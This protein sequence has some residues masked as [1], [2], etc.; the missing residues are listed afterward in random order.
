MKYEIG[1]K[2]RYYREL[3]GLSQKEFASQIGVSNGRVSNWELGINRPDADT[4]VLICKALQVSA[5]DL[6]TVPI[7]YGIALSAKEKQLITE[8]RNH[9]EM[10]NAI[11][12]LLGITDN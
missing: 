9:P 6:L 8:Y 1:R 5:D 10:R 11:H 2:I 3:R 7:F 4:L 12:T